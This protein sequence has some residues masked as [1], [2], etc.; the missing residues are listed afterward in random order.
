MGILDPLYASRK[1]NQAD[2]LNFLARSLLIHQQNYMK[3][4]IDMS[5]SIYPMDIC[6]VKYY[7]AYQVY[8]KGGKAYV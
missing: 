1:S 5:T 3:L 7:L 8:S 6:L 4:C 2:F